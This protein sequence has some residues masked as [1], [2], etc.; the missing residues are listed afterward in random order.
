[1]PKEI[2]RKF[3]AAVIQNNLTIT[4]SEETADDKLIKCI[5]CSS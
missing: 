4:I 5:C 3:L 2:A 1:M